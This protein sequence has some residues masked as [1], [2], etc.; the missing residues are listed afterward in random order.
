M[1]EYIPELIKSG[2]TSLKIEGRM[3]TAYYVATVV[4]AYRMAIDEFY[5][6]PENWK[7]NPMWMEELKKVVIDI[8]HQVLLE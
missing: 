2:I 7:F 5:R 3:K 4:R 1:I 6:D 8:L